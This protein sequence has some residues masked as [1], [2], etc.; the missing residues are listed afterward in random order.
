MTTF[1]GCESCDFWICHF[2]YKRS[3]SDWIPTDPSQSP[4]TTSSHHM[5]WLSTHES[6]DKVEWFFPSWHQLP[7]TCCI[8]QKNWMWEHTQD[9]TRCGCVH[10]PF[11]RTIPDCPCRP[12]HE[13][14]SH[15]WA[16]ACSLLSQD[17]V[18]IRES[19]ILT[20]P[21]IHQQMIILPG[22]QLYH[23][24]SKNLQCDSF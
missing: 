10:G 15:Q 8:T 24:P 3:P 20:E 21:V 6:H 7:K 18:M 13:G 22:N 19:C 2:N 11:P 14:S 17:S 23:P 5:S 12:R 16:P 1:R 4:P 9:L